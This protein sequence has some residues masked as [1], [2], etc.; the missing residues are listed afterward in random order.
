MMTAKHNNTDLRRSTYSTSVNNLS[1]SWI[2]D[3]EKGFVSQFDVNTNKYLK[4]PNSWIF[5]FFFFVNQ[6]PILSH[7]SN[8]MSSKRVP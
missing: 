1:V 8:S 6:V 7:H 2:N 3:P 4:I 5:F